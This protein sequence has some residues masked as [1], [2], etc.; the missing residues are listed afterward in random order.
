MMHGPR[1]ARSP[2]YTIS[3]DVLRR[4]SM[5]TH[6]SAEFHQIG[7]IYSL[8]FF[9]FISFNLLTLCKLYNLSNSTISYTNLLP[10]IALLNS[11]WPFFP[12]LFCNNK[13]VEKNLYKLIFIFM[14]QLNVSHIYTVS[15]MITCIL[16]IQQTHHVDFIYILYI[17]IM[18]HIM[19]ISYMISSSWPTKNR[20]KLFLIL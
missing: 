7:Y 9:N 6:V 14:L 12:H 3:N 16:Y 13:F 19:F 4:T 1:P 15:I 10:P 5:L 2:I 17:I 18:W 8:F 11:I 20:L